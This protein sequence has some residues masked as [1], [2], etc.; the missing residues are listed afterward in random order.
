[1][2][3]RATLDLASAQT[4]SPPP[5]WHGDPVAWH[6]GLQ[7]SV[8]AQ[9]LGGVAAQKQPT[10]A[11]PSSPV[12][13]LCLS[14]PPGASHCPGPGPSPPVPASVIYTFF[15]HLPSAEAGPGDLESSCVSLH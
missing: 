3:H 8:C 13:R 12:W 9:T 11:V 2:P 1:M 7:S 15:V 6:W 4:S 10:V 14:M 5:G